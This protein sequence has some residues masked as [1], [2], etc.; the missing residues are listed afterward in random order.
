MVSRI[1]V[2]SFSKLREFLSRFSSMLEINWRNKQVDLDILTNERLRNPIDSLKNTLRLFKYQNELF[3]AKLPKMAEIGLIQL[4]SKNVRDKIQPTAK[5]RIATIERKIPEVIRYRNI[6]AKEWLSA[7]IKQ[8]DKQSLSTVQDY[9]DQTQHYQETVDEFQ[10][11][12]DNV[13]MYGQLYNVFADTEFQLKV[14]KEDK[15]SYN[16]SL[17]YISKL[18]NIIQTVES[19]QEGNKEKFKK[20]LNELIP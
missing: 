7:R 11:Y 10:T 18:A 13:D 14:K 19:Q 1:I 8:L 5:E 16:E 3:S 2:S 12:R 17:Q 6:K 4:D 20:D 9:V 15:D